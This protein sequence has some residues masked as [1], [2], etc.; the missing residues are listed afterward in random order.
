MIRTVLASAITAALIALTTVPAIA[1]PAETAF[2]QKLS[3]NWIGK[4]KLTGA[5]SGAVSCRIVITARGQSL[6]YQGRCTI[7]DLAAQ[8]FNGAITYNDKLKRYE[9]RTMNGV[10][11]DR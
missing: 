2:L 4:G 10:V 3:A 7:P 6:K 5:Q 9:S 11:P 1:G 8:A